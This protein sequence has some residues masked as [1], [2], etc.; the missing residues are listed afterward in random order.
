MRADLS[1]ASE[2]PLHPSLFAGGVV[3]TEF[4]LPSCCK[5]VLVYTGLV[6]GSRVGI[7]YQQQSFLLPSPSSTPYGCF[8]PAPGA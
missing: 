3:L 2:V 5:A 1:F 8:S 6:P 4:F 7:H